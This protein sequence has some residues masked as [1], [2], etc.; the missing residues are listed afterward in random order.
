MMRGLAMRIGDPA[1]KAY[2]ENM[3]VSSIPYENAQEIINRATA[4]IGAR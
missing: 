1:G 4:A 2:L 3:S